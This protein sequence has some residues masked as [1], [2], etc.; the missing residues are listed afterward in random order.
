MGRRR[1]LGLQEGE[2]FRLIPR[3]IAFKICDF[4]PLRVDEVSRWQAVCLQ[5]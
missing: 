2:G 4:L 5:G 1:K 3:Y